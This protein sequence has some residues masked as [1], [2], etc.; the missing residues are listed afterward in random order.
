MKKTRILKTLPFI[1]LVLSILFLALS[2]AR[3]PI[4][5][6][7]KI[8]D[9]TE[10]KLAARMEILDTYIRKALETEEGSWPEIGKLPDDMVIYRYVNDS[11]QSWSNQFAV[12]NDDISSKLVF[13]RMSNMMD[14]IVS[15]L[16]EIEEKPPA[17]DTELVLLDEDEDFFTGEKEEKKEKGKPGRKKKN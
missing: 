9:K 13:Q 1:C 10:S 7:E 4:G 15:P 14:R 3:S 5:D 6:V 11:L 17:E 8:A 16:S 2:M 12:L